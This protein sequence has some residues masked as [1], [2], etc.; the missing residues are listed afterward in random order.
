MVYL[1]VAII[2]DID[3]TLLRNGDQPI[4]HTIDYFNSLPGPRI[5]VTGRNAKT[6]AETVRQLR[7]AGIR[8]TTLYMNPTGGNDAQFKYETAMRLK[9][10]YKI[11]VAIDNN[12]NMRAAYR[13]AGVK[14]QDPAHLPDTKK[15]WDVTFG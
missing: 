6:R 9:K 2:C 15:I 13:R 14:T 7:A 3:D 11:E 4:Q 10:Q 8:F 12:P 5:L 1:N